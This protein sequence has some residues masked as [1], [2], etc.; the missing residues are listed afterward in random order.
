MNSKKKRDV[1]QLG[2]QKKLSTSLERFII[3]KRKYSGIESNQSFD[4]ISNKLMGEFK[5]KYNQIYSLYIDTNSIE[6]TSSSDSSEIRYPLNS[7]VSSTYLYEDLFSIN[8][9]WDCSENSNSLSLSYQITTLNLNLSWNFRKQ[10][11]KIIDQFFPISTSMKT[12]KVEWNNDYCLDVLVE[13]GKII[14]IWICL[15][16]YVLL[17]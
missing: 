1:L 7:N 15:R 10:E 16:N 13:E 14:T 9:T 3:Q 2:F 11:T 8:F 12:Q 6:L 4:S 17:P 5:K